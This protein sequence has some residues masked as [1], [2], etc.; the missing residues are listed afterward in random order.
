MPATAAGRPGASAPRH[1]PPT[2]G[3][4]HALPGGPAPKEI[5]LRPEAPREL[6]GAHN[7][8]GDPRHTA[9]LHRLGRALDA[10]ILDVNDDGFIP[11]GSPLE[12]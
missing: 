9:V 12:G 7:L 8:A 11:E 5:G 3:P 2:T 4:D 10:H 1:G 6:P